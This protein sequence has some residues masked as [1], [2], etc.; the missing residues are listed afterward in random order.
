LILIIELKAALIATLSGAKVRKKFG[1]ASFSKEKFVLLSKEFR[2]WGTDGAR[3]EG[4][5]NLI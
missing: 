3:G 2:N 4:D 5:I 1:I